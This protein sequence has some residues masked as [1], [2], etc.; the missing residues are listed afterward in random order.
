M[1]PGA[2]CLLSLPS[3]CWRFVLACPPFFREVL[4]HSLSSL[5]QGRPPTQPVTALVETGRFILFGGW[6]FFFI[7]ILIALVTVEIIVAV[8]D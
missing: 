4:P 7:I 1:G 2:W 3:I 8:F 6:G 5:L